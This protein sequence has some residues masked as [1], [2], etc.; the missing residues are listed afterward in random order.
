MTRAWRVAAAL[1]LVATAA[2]LFAWQARESAGPAAFDAPRATPAPAAAP[3]VPGPRPDPAAPTAAQPA[4]DASQAC[5]DTADPWADAEALKAAIGP[6]GDVL[7][8]SDDPE[9]W[10]AAAAL[11]RLPF[12]AASANFAALERALA[13]RP[14]H[15]L[16]AILWLGLCERARDDPACAAGRDERFA[17]GQAGHNGVVWSLLADRHFRRGEVEAGFAALRRA[18]AAP[19]FDSGFSELV[20]LVERGLAA[21]TGLTL[22]ERAGVAFGT[23]AALLPVA[24]AASLACREPDVL[25]THGQACL[26]YAARLENEGSSLLEILVGTGLQAALHDSAGEERLA[27]QV[28]E[29][30]A[31]LRARYLHDMSGTMERWLWLSEPV[32]AEYLEELH[33][34]GELAAREFVVAEYRR[35]NEQGGIDPCKLVRRQ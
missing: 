20:L 33:A 6:A 12:D 13:R 8:A 11:G 18:A 7:L 9:H 17:V 5:A 27:A 23:A 31:D 24:T 25:A 21:S 32:L 35:R 15:P 29:R 10:L 30:E 16:A 14:E 19:V 28:R 22:A 3:A 26:A 2:A 4:A 1:V 34:H